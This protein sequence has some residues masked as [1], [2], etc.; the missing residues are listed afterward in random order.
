MS[1]CPISSFW[2]SSLWLFNSE[3]VQGIG[4]SQT[5]SGTLEV[6]PSW[7]IIHKLP[8][9]QLSPR[10]LQ[11]EDVPFTIPSSPTSM[12]RDIDHQGDL[13]EGFLVTP[14]CL[15]TMYFLLLPHH[16]FFSIIT[17]HSILHYNDQRHKNS[18]LVGGFSPPISKICFSQIGS[19][20][21]GSGWK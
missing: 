10:Y 17:K 4:F 15:S 16:V 12:I 7:K 1:S 3:S 5:S 6:S 13:S 20:R 14:S 8:V 19:S 21:Q 11:N 18:H 2:H 9:V